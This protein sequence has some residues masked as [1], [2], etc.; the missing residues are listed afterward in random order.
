MTTDEQPDS[1]AA[2]I[3]ALKDLVQSKGWL[4]YRQCVLDE[5]AGDFEN[6]ITKAL[7][8]TDSALALDRMRQVAAVRKAGLRWLKLPS[9]RLKT[10][11]EQVERK[12]DIA[13]SPGRRPIGL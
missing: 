7:D 5:I 9:E 12:D 6:Q 13:H 10:L 3:E 8:N 11:T 2:Q 4:L 1:P